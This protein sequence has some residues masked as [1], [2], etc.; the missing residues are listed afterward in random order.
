L[1]PSSF[2]TV[3]GDL[4]LSGDHLDLENNVAPA[5]FDRV[6]AEFLCCFDQLLSVN[7]FSRSQRLRTGA[8]AV[9]RTFCSHLS[10]SR[11]FLLFTSGFVDDSFNFHATIQAVHSI[12]LSFCDLGG[13]N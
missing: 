1:L 11:F 9:D 6:L 7:R 13:V 3:D 12:V 10:G 2:E 4:F 5:E 8:L